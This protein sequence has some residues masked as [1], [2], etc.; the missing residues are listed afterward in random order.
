MD[1][2]FP[3]RH[4]AEVSHG[5]YPEPSRTPVNSGEQ[6]RSARTRKSNLGIFRGVADFLFFFFAFFSPP[7]SPAAGNLATETEKM[8]AMTET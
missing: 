8:T 2:E 3:H 6:V 1:R 7:T 5:V 4:S